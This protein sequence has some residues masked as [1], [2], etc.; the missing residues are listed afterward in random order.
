MFDSIARLTAAL[1]SRYAIGTLP[2][3]LLGAA[4][5]LAIVTGTPRP[6]AAQIQLDVMTFNIRT[7]NIRDGDNAWPYRKKL[8]AE[9]IRAF[10]PQVVG[11]QEAIEEQIEYLASALPDYRWLGMDRRL[12]GGEGL[13]EATP[14]FYRHDEMTPI[15]SG[16]FWLT[17]TPDVPPVPSTGSRRRRGGG[18]IVTWARFHH[19]ATGRAV[20]VF[21]THLSP[22][23]GQG[24]I[25]AVNLI[26]ERVGKVPAGSAV[27][28]MG[29]FNNAGEESDLWQIA[30]SH[31]LNDAWVLADERQGPALTLGG[32]GPPEAGYPERVD[33]ILVGGP[34]GVRSIETVLH[35]DRGRYPS[36]HYPVAASLEVN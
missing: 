9:T 19:L 17:E 14:I 15:E 34:I 1:E 18:R 11:M 26:L 27:I 4:V 25:D 31:G 8:V 36:D 30:T 16:N 24:Q 33:W 12:N 13:S 29:D 3:Y 7:S 35:N 32:F 5:V 21:N 23:R 28:V 2:R 20:Y 6:A 22:R 10:A